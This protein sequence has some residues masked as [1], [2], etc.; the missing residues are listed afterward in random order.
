ME[1]LL[2]ALALGLMGSFHCV[3]MCGPIALSLPLRGNGFAPKLA[4]GILYNV[5]RSLGYGA[6]GAAF[7]FIGQGFQMLGFQ[8]WVSIAMGALMIIAILLP[9]V[10]RKLSLGKVD[11]FLGHVRKAI[12]RIF[13]VRS[14]GSLFLIGVLN[15]LLPCGLVYL[16]IAG[17]IGVGNAFMGFMY[18]IL[19]GLGTIPMMLAV[20]F[21]GNII[22]GTV[23]NKINKIIPYVVVFIGIVFILRGLCLGIPYLSPPIEKLSPNIQMNGM[24]TKNSHDESCCTKK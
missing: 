6:M 1:I 14:Y 8:R 13:K 17:S 21:I 15:S 2:S 23:R 11:V 5:G 7:G 12:K 10:F 18:M 20:T 24:D 3:G 22:S 4:S 16:A 9:A 19:F